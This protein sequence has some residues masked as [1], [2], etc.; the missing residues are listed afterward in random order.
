[1]QVLK[2]MSGRK[3]F[4]MTGRL[5]QNGPHRIYRADLSTPFSI[6]E[7]WKTAPYVLASL[8]TT[9]LPGNKVGA[10]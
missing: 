4:T 6:H 3:P 10:A 8:L 7:F 9:Y 1:V 2:A 5:H